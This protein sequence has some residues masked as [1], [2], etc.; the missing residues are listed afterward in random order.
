MLDIYPRAILKCASGHFLHIGGSSTVS[1]FAH[2]VQNAIPHG[3]LTVDRSF[4]P[5]ISA[6]RA[7]EGESTS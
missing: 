1:V 5:G 2:P 7:A 4:P 3:L 6:G